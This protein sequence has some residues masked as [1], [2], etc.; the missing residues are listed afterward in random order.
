MLSTAQEVGGE[1]G[2]VALGVWE[3]LIGTLILNEVT[4]DEQDGI[5][6]I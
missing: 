6:L 2:L 1:V 4:C 5:S 3:S